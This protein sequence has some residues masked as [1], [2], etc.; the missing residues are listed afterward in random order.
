MDISF[1]GGNDNFKLRV[2]GIIMNGDSVLLDKHSVDNK[3]RLPGGRVSINESSEDAIKR[4]LEE[5]IGVIF[6]ID[7]FVG[8]TEE[9]YINYEGIKTHCINL[10]YKAKFSNPEEINKIEFDRLEDDHGTS[11]QHGFKWVKLSD[12]ESINLV[13]KEIKKCIINN[14]SNI[15]Y[16]IHDIKYK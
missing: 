7:S 15:H 1:K 13:P 10:Y 2:T 16:I 11:V 3:Y 6:D 14:E 4:E 9:F 8:I 5:E 12:L